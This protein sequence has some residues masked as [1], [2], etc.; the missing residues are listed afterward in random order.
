MIT[1]KQGKKGRTKFTYTART[2]FGDKAPDPFEMM[3]AE[4][5]RCRKIN[6]LQSTIL[7]S[8]Q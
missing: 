6:C 5:K 4:E 1:T 7:N 3:N 2:G 8:A